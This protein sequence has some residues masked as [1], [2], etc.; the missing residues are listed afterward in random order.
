MIALR[1]G[2]R[3]RL[4]GSAEQTGAVAASPYTFRD[5][6]RVGVIWDAF[7]GW[8]AVVSVSSLVRVR[9]KPAPRDV[10]PEARPV[11]VGAM[12]GGGR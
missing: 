12:A 5:V 7:P 6:R 4:R 9:T 11:S 10:V 1:I 8:I 2:D 3:I